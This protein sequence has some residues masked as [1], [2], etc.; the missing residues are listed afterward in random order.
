MTV[1]LKGPPCGNRVPS[2]VLTNASGDRIG[3]CPDCG[4]SFNVRSKGEVK[5]PLH[6]T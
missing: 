4:R 5:L 2:V 1:K 6:T 3:I